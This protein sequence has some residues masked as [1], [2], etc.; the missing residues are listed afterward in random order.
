MGK[1]KV[2]HFK[3]LESKF[4]AIV[5]EI[6]VYI[7]YWQRKLGLEYWDIYSKMIPSLCH[8]NTSIRACIR[9]S[10]EYRNASIEFFLPTLFDEQKR[11]REY[12]VVHELCHAVINPMENKKTVEKHL[13]YVV[14][15]MANAL[16]RVKYGKRT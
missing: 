7:D 1:K 11:E 13:E 3:G 15:D 5:D 8:R 16:L 9:C 6:E 4:N 2:K 10:W 12:V 14:V